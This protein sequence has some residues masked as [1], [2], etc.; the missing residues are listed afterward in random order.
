MVEFFA[1]AEFFSEPLLRLLAAVLVGGAIGMD[2][3]YRGRAAGFRTHILVC[4]ASSLLMIL[5]DFQWIMAADLRPDVIRMDPARMAQGIMTGIGFLGAGVI[6]QDKQSVRGLTTA[7]S[8]WIT[9][10]IGIVLGAGYYFAAIVSTLLTLI[11]LAVFNKLIDVLPMRR[12]AYLT[13]RF[14]RGD[15]WSEIEVRKWLENSSITISSLSYKL[16]Q[17]GRSLSYQM[18]IRTTKPESF[19]EIARYLLQVPI[20]QEFNLRPFGD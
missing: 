7:A 17:K 4:L 18:T 16:E 3:A 19:N 6:M 11:T 2:R 10:T 13:L 9:A 20:V 5:M 12:Y 1:P 15:E 8:I 14:H